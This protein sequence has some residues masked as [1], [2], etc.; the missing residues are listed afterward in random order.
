M[1]AAKGGERGQGG[2][3]DE[4]IGGNLGENAGDAAGV[5]GQQAGEAVQVEDV[6]VVQVILGG[7][8]GKLLQQGDGIEVEPAELNPAGAA[9]GA[10]TAFTAWKAA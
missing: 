3:L 5:G 1:G 4:G 2:G 8:G 9:E 6:A 10:C 7:S